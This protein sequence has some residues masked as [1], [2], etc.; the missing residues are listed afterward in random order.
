MRSSRNQFA[1]KPLPLPN[2]PV[3]R[4]A[5]LVL[6]AALS[7]SVAAQPASTGSY[8]ARPIRVVVPFAAG[9]S[10]DITARR[11]EP[12]MS[13]T[14]GQHLVVDNRAGAVGVIGSDMV[15]RAS[16]DG[17][18][19]LM[20]AVSSHSIAA[21]LRPKSLPYDVIKDFTP[22]A[23]VSVT[24]LILISANTSPFKTFAEMASFA[25]QNPGKLNYAS[26]GI[27]TAS[28]LYMEQ[29]KLAMGLD[30]AFVPYRS[31]GQQM[32]DTIS[33]Q[34]HM[35]LPSLIGGLPQVQ[36]GKARLLAIGGA[37]RHASFPDVP[38][39]ADASGMAGFD[40]AVW[41][42]FV[43]PRGMPDAAVAR[44]NAEM[45]TALNSPRVTKVIEDGGAL[46]AHTSPSGFGALIQSGA[47]DA[48][49]II[50][51]LNIELQ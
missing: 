27:G 3:M 16:P 48:Q 24:P 9:S 4:C 25:K 33:G 18:T 32:A 12:H 1:V 30:I 15:T 22:I 42:G 41:Y 43:G 28:H 38:T 46:K 36:G 6:A 49:K 31:T 21:A 8:P 5:W 20:T 35:S 13:R 10:T 11:L 17:Y 7:G 37:S 40:A 34:V 29:I 26:S 2:H 39:F 47:L 14:L 50:K 45:A 19:L 44:I 51:T 23:R